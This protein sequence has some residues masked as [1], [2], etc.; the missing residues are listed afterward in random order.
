MPTKSMPNARSAGAGF[1]SDP[2]KISDT[3]ISKTRES[4]MQIL[5][6]AVKNHVIH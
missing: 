5:T 3:R 1:S 2:I 4:L 6:R